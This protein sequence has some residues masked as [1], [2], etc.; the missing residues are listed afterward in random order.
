MLYYPDDTIQH[1]GVILG[2]H[3]VAAHVYSGRPRGFP[4]HGGRVRVA[5]RLSAVTGACLVVRR[6]VFESA[7]GLDEAL[8]VA[9]NDIDFCLRLRE[10]GYANVWTPFAE[11]YHH[12]S[13]SR[14]SDE[15]GE[16]RDRFAREIERMRQRWDGLLQDDPAYNPNLSLGSKYFDLASP[17][18]HHDRRA[19]R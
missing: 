14:G 2:V 11:L 5:Q 13:A 7:G 10:L 9:F 17:P 19:G 12:E 16:K 8:E 18:R 1:A 6:E 15:E 4:G 3:G